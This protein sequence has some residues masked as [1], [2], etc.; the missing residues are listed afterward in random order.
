MDRILFKTTLSALTILLTSLSL[1]LQAKDWQVNNEN[2]SVRYIYSLEGAAFRGRFREFSAEINFDP[3][4][5][6]EGKILGIVNIVSSKSSSA[7]HDEYLMEEDWFDPD[8]HPISQFTSEKI[9]RNDNGGNFIAYGN[10]TLAGTSQPI[11]MEFDFNIEESK[12][13]FSGSFEIKRLLF[14]V[15]W[16]TT[17]WIADEVDVQIKLELN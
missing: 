11:E 1:N 17:N 12:A 10:L 5:P 3:K 4:K 7:E 15:G 13:N 14:G 2:S 6:E 16:D 8:N 9:I